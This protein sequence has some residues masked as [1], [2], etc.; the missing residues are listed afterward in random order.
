MTMKA[1]DLILNKEESFYTR[2]LYI[3]A[4]KSP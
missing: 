1:N 2:F 3:S 4:H